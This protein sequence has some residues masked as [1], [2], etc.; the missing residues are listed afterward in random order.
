M[1][2]ATLSRYFAMPSRSVA[3]MCWV[4]HLRISCRSFLIESTAMI[5]GSQR[6]EITPEASSMSRM[7]SSEPTPCS[8]IR[9]RTK[10]NAASSLWAVFKLCRKDMATSAK[11]GKGTASLSC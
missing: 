10:A 3:R 2:A 11:D 5:S 1:A 4:C 9:L 8:T 7:R 6:S